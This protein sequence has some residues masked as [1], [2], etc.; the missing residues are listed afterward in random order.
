MHTHRELFTGSVGRQITNYS[1]LPISEQ[2]GQKKNLQIEAKQNASQ[3]VCCFLYLK[4]VIT[5]IVK[6]LTKRTR[7]YPV[8]L[9]I[10][11]YMRIYNT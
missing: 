3:N 8:T 2:A 5:D 4:N 6:H 10:R 9:D 11:K 7:E 1:A